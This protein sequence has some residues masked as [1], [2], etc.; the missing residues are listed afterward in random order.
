MNPFLDHDSPFL[1]TLKTCSQGHS[2]TDVV[3][4]LQHRLIKAPKTLTTLPLLYEA[5]KQA[6]RSHLQG[7]APPKGPGSLQWPFVRFEALQRIQRAV[8]SDPVPKIHLQRRSHVGRRVSKIKRHRRE[9]V[10][11][12][13]HATNNAW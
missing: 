9:D 2:R 4:S 7:R 5:Q 10:A 11:S 13:A 12:Q 3:V 1:L 8:F 6:A